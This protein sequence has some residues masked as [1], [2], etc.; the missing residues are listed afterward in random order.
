MN[1]DL[2][3]RK[4]LHLNDSS[5]LTS[6]PSFK[7]HFCPISPYLIVFSIFINNMFWDETELKYSDQQ[8]R[9]FNYLV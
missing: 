9:A 4:C 2:L 7:T 3:N 8:D 5:L 1:D 6:S